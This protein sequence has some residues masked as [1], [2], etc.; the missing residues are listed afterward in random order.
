MLSLVPVKSVVGVHN[1]VTVRAGV[2]EGVGKMFGL[3]VV[4]DETNSLLC[5]GTNFTGV[6]GPSFMCDVLIKIFK[7]PK[8]LSIS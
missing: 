3:N 8:L 4:S 6:R 2:G 5:V 1:F 7:T